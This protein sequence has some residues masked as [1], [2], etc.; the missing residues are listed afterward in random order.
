MRGWKTYTVYKPMNPPFYA[1]IYD[2]F[3]SGAE[4][5]AGISPHRL[6]EPEIM[7]RVDRDLPPVLATTTSTRSWIR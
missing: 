1:P 2:V 7:F 4:I 6:I 3:A 5:P